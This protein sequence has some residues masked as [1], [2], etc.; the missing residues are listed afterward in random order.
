MLTVYHNPRCSK[1]RDCLAF[2]DN[3]E[4]PYQ[5][6]KYLEK[7]PSFEEL[8]LLIKQ[9]NLAPIDLIRK[10]EPI[11]KKKYERKDLSDDE[12]IQVMSSN[13]IL[14][15]RPIVVNGNKAVIARPIEKA[16][17]IL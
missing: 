9:L 10:N 15:E 8:K 17:E 2:F 13:P 3:S 11:W 5:V 4:T 7:P 12:L 1:S 16:A 14:I 6:I